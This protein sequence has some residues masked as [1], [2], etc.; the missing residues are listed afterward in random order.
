MLNP[1]T[2]APDINSPIHG[3]HYRLSSAMANF[4][5]LSV[6]VWSGTNGGPTGVVARLLASKAA[7]S[8]PFHSELKTGAKSTPGCA[9]SNL[10]CSPNRTHALCGGVSFGL[11]GEMLTSPNFPSFRTQ[12]RGSR[13][14]LSVQ[15]LLAHT[16]P[17][18]PGSKAR[19]R[20]A[21]HDSRTHRKSQARRIILWGGATRRWP[22]GVNI[23]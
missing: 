12:S 16:G 18:D 2:L 6:F 7:G 13:D 20:R 22:E 17:T 23:Q 3:L 5:R 11:Y 1:V 19:L 14:G 4:C 15:A 9:R 21:S 10:P 8:P